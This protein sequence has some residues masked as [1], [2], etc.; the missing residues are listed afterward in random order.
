MKKKVI[1]IVSDVE[2]SHHLEWFTRQIKDQYELKVV[3]IG[4]ENTYHEK[5][6]R[7]NNIPVFQIGYYSKGDFFYA[8][9]KIFNF[10]K[11]ERPSLIH[12]HFWLATIIGI[13]ISYLLRIPNR[14]ITRHHGNFHHL[15]YKKGVWMDILLNRLATLIISPTVIIRKLMIQSEYVRS[16]KIEVINHG[17]D[18]NYYRTTTKERIQTIRERYDIPKT[19]PVIGVIS[20]HI[21]WKGIQY[22]IAAFEEVV[23]SVP[24]AHLILANANGKYRK[25][26]EKRLSKLPG[27]SYT[28]IE[29]END[30]ATLYSMFDIFVHV[31]IDMGSESF[32][33]TYIEALA[34]GK[35]CI[36]TLSGV[37]PDFIRHEYNALVVDYK[38]ESQIIS[39]ILRLLSD[40]QLVDRLITN[41]R[42]SA[43]QYSDVEMGQRVKSVYANQFLKLK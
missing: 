20:R 19:S 3:L 42:E 10:L 21:E 6:L 5:F 39:S 9:R 22:T 24:T 15:Y 23:K 29:Y 28:L 16:T 38:N 26:L 33:L 17:I 4:R 18:C 27:D 35:P 11:M 41:G 36:F 40:Q 1:H 31:P 37:A 7:V 25:V 12:S 30:I 14:V 13:P 34:A 2:K 8:F 32:G 43:S